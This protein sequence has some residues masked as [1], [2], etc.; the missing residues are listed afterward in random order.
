[1][2]KE[3]PTPTEAKRSRGRPRKT[4]AQIAYTAVNPPKHNR[5]SDFVSRPGVAAMAATTLNDD[6]LL[7]RP[8]V[9]AR[10][11]IGTSQIYRL[12]GEGRFP[13]AINISAKSVRWR[14][15]ELRAWL[16]DPVSYR[17]NNNSAPLA[18]AA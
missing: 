7:S 17:A 6:R 12:M 14:P 15:A 4:P 3:I 8:E 9:I 16:A 11:G 5:K 18:R 13:R 10:T 1:M 2:T